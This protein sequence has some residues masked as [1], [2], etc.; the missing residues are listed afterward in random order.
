MIT[1]TQLATKLSTVNNMCFEVCYDTQMTEKKA[2]D[3]LKQLQSAP[4]SKKELKDL[5]E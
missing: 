3:I 5:T 2:L 4:Q 1:A